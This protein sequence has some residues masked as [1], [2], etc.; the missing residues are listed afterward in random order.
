[1]TEALPVLLLAGCGKMGSALAQGWLR[2]AVPL[3]RQIIAIDPGHKE[4]PPRQE[5][6]LTRFASLDALPLDARPDIVILA[7]KPQQL[8]A[9]LPAYA[10]RFGTAPLYLSIAAGRTLHWLS[11]QLGPQARVV[12]AMPNLPATVG[13]GVTAGCANTAATPADRQ[14]AQRLL[15]AVGH[16]LWLDEERWMDAVTAV[17]GSGPAYFF[18]LAEALERAGVEAGLSPA[19]AHALVKHTFCGSAALAEAGGEAFSVLAGAVASPGGT[20]EAALN[21]L[22]RPGGMPDQLRKA[23]AAAMARSKELSE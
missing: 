13:H 10:Q 4:L 17:S 20:T 2:Q 15:E 19:V 7:V 1:M 11:R 21:L 16:F 14:A 6:R 9:I 3:F 5:D 12:R 22:N 8:S 18:L 23:V